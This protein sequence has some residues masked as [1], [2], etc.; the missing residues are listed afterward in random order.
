MKDISVVVEMKNNNS[1][2]KIDYHHNNL[3]F[4]LTRPKP[5]G[6]YVIVCHHQISKSDFDWS[7]QSC[8]GIISEKNVKACSLLE[9]QQDSVIEVKIT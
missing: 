1:K 5:N 6:A 8:S 7:K 2:T 3:S 4:S 9:S